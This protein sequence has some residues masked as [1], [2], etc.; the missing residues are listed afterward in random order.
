M[1]AQELMQVKYSVS[2]GMIDPTMSEYESTGEVLDYIRDTRDFMIEEVNELM[3][4][5]GGGRDALKPWTTAYDHLRATDFEATDHIKSEAI[6]MLC[7]ALNICLAAGVT[8]ENIDEEYDKV[9]SKNER[10]QTNGY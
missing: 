2:T 4:E 1:R 3:I 5:I 8:P 6:D 9:H 10:R 7:F